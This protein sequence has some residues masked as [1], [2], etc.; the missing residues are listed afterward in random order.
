MENE[1]NK[2][3]VNLAHNVVVY[4]NDAV[5]ALLGKLSPI[6]SNTIGHMFVDFRNI[7]GAGVPTNIHMGVAY[8]NADILGKELPEDQKGVVIA[9][10][11]ECPDGSQVKLMLEIETAFAIMNG[12]AMSTRAAYEALGEDLM[13][14]Q[15]RNKTLRGALNDVKRKIKAGQPKNKRMS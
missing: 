5:S 6:T 14:A 9:I 4:P 15:L 7:P 2:E 11:F 3:E 12:L 13:H 10:E 8:S 1:V